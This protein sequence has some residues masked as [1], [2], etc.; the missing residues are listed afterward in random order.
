MGIDRGLGDL[1]VT[2]VVSCHSADWGD[3]IEWDLDDP[4]VGFMEGCNFDP[5]PALQEGDPSQSSHVLIN[6][7]QSEGVAPS[8]KPS[9]SFLNFF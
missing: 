8:H 3:I 6:A 5:G 7:S 9:R 1:E 2:C 4:G